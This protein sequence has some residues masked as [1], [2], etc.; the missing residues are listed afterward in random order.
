MQDKQQ[1]TLQGDQ[2][3]PPPG[4]WLFKFQEE[5]LGP[6]PAKEIIERMFAGEVD[7]S[8]QISLEDGE[9]TTVQTLQEFR[10]F[11]YQA[12]AHLRAQRARAEAIQAA[13]KRRTRNTI[14]VAVAGVFVVIISF[15]AT[16]FLVI[17]RPWSGQDAL[18]LW[19]DKHVPLLMISMANAHEP[20]ADSA[21]D[22]AGINIDQIL[23]DDAPALVAIQDIPSGK[24]GAKAA[25]PKKTIGKKAST[26]ASKKKGSSTAGTKTASVGRL[27]NEEIT[28]VV[29]APS[30]LRRL[31]S[32]IRRE[33]K[34]NDDLPET[35]VLDFSIAN[36]GKVGQVRMDAIKLDGG[37]LHACFK[38]KLASLK[39][40]PFSGQVRNV[41]LPF[42]IGQ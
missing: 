32:C 18:Q 29:Y 39:F 16:F 3:Y 15:F 25:E 34:R 19:A 35:I 7:E 36:D 28:A 10:P 14:R 22:L 42:N 33:I 37:P 20:D 13:Q 11:L 6:V 30:N 38:Q 8:T 12:K 23:I 5:I 27:R 41:T 26:S 31:Y 1:G 9:W 17:H 40:R 24:N 21:E 4:D 2:A